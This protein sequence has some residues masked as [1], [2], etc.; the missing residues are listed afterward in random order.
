MLDAAPQGMRA[1]L[2]ISPPGSAPQAARA[3][4]SRAAQA[5][6]QRQQWAELYGDLAAALQAGGCPPVSWEEYLWAMEAVCSRAF[7]EGYRGEWAGCWRAHGGRMRHGCYSPVVCIG[8]T[9]R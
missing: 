1:P 8:E 6:I 2:F 5:G 3:G 7:A 9:R 4:S